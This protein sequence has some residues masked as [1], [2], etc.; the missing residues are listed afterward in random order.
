[1]VKMPRGGAFLAVGCGGEGGVFVVHCLVAMVIL[2]VGW[3]GSGA[4]LVFHHRR[5]PLRFKACEY[6]LRRGAA[7]EGTP[8]VLLCYA[9]DGRRQ[10]CKFGEFWQFC[11]DGGRVEREVPRRGMGRG[12][13]TDGGDDGVILASLSTV[14][15][16]GEGLL[17]TPCHSRMESA[18]A[19]FA[20]ARITKFEPSSSPSSVSASRRKKPEDRIS[21]GDMTKTA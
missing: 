14:D 18:V 9:S 17:S 11:A 16:N 3:L 1:M 15:I 6:A 2:L 19:V 8:I 21:K 10:D 7:A 5:A 12:I 13:A 4:W 20:I